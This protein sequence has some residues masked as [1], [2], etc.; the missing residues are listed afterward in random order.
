M[1]KTGNRALAIT[2]LLS[3]ILLVPM[4]ICAAKVPFTPSPALK[5]IFQQA[6]QAYFAPMG[7]DLNQVINTEPEIFASILGLVMQRQRNY[8]EP[9]PGYIPRFEALKEEIVSL[10]HKIAQ[11]NISQRPANGQAITGTA[12]EYIFYR[13]MNGESNNWFIE[14]LQIDPARVGLPFML[15]Q[16]AAA[17]EPA[18]GSDPTPPGLGAFY[19]KKESDSI[20]L[21]DKDAEPNNFPLQAGLS[22]D[23]QVCPDYKVGGTPNAYIDTNNNPDDRTF[24][25]CSYPISAIVQTPF[26]EG[27]VNGTRLV[28]STQEGKPK[29]LSWKT[30]YVNGLKHGMEE[31]YL[32]TDSGQRWLFSQTIYINGKRQKIKKKWNLTATG[33]RYLEDL[34]PYENDRENGV[35]E[36]YSISKS[37]QCY[38]YRRTSWS[39]GK[40]H[41]VSSTYNEDGSIKYVQKYNNGHLIN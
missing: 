1:N 23:S 29:Y 33:N 26:E 35:E 25:E 3:S 2:T 32:L 40:R 27:E 31:S 19:L 10:L 22:S 28:F 37:G 5:T 16:V 12:L 9:N 41:G 15:N 13:D 20:R 7:S 21:L 36:F 24:I 14:N 6:Q 18:S 39:N 30:P 38:L 34:I 11:A 8:L 4:V 17:Q